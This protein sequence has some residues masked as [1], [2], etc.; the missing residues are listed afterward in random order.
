MVCKGIAKVDAVPL[1]H[2]VSELK[3]TFATSLLPL[4]RFVEKSNRVKPILGGLAVRKLASG[5]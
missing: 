3:L 2:R 1:Q 5:C 4:A